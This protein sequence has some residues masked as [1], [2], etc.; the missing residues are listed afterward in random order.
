MLGMDFMEMSL[1][2]VKSIAG[3][4]PNVMIMQEQKFFWSTGI[5]EY[6]GATL[7]QLQCV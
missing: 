5:S 7:I 2:R 3:W 1:L 6:N 4:A